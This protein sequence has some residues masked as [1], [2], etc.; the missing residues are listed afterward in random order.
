MFAE[1]LDELIAEYGGTAGTY[2]Q[3][4]NTKAMAATDALIKDVRRDGDGGLGEDALLGTLCIRVSKFASGFS[5]SSPVYPAAGDTYTVASLATP[6]RVLAGEGSVE[7]VAG[8]V[9]LLRLR[10]DRQRGAA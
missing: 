8:E 7:N 10:R 4:S 6:W 9:Y 1:V 5:S 3:G 2:G